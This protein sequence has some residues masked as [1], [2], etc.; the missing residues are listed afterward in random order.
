MVQV[1]QGAPGAA[2]SGERYAVSI[3]LTV[4]DST[5]QIFHV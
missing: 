1:V 3:Y 5:S 2:V 4:I